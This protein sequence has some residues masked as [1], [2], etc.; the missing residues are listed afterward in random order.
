MQDGSPQV[1]PALTGASEDRNS[2]HTPFPESS[3][4]QSLPVSLRGYASPHPRWLWAQLG[5]PG[6]E[7]RRKGPAT[8]APCPLGLLGPKVFGIDVPDFRSPRV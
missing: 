4:L 7:G 2:L 8:L 1:C 5:Q 6:S 3:P